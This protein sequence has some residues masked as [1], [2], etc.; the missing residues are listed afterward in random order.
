MTTLS[1]DQMYAMLI[2]DGWAP[3]MWRNKFL[4]MYKEDNVVYWKRN[5]VRWCRLNETYPTRGSVREIS[6]GRKR[7]EAKP[8]E[9]MFAAVRQLEDDLERYA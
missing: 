7:F 8:M 6:C 9:P 5:H 2:L 4:G 1:Y 3:C